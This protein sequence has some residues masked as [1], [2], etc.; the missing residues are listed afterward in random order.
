MLRSWHGIRIGDECFQ[1]VYSLQSQRN[2]ACVPSS[3]ESQAIE[4]AIRRR[5]VYVKQERCVVV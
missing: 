3:F 5:S 2:H 4:A 1:W